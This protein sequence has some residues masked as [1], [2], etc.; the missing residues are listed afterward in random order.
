MTVKELKK[1][2]YFTIKP[3]ENPTEK[4]VYIRGEYD[5]ATK[6]YSCGRFDDISYEKMLSGDKVVYVDFTF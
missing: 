2:D 5:R 3:I 6:K 4:Q 1:G